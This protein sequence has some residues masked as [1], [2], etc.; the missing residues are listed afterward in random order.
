MM[1]WIIDS[2][3]G[4]DPGLPICRLFAMMIDSGVDALSPARNIKTQI[5][6]SAVT[7]DLRKWGHEILVVLNEFAR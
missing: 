2:N 7:H 3:K 4:V 1:R 5:F 6:E